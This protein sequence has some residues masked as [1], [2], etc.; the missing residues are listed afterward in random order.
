MPT[1]PTGDPALDLAN[2]LAPAAAL[3]A[4]DFAPAG[5]DSAA[6]VTLHA[7]TF[8]LPPGRGDYGSGA[9]EIMSTTD[10]FVAL[11]EFD[12]ASVGTALFAQSG[13][14]LPLDPESFSTQQLQRPQRGQGG[15][16]VFFSE[17]GRAFCAYVVIGSWAQ[18]AT[19]VPL[20][21]QLLAGLRVA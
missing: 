16:Q 1:P 7:A 20:A 8:P 2:G 19:L 14:T 21:S 15:L 17:A 13:L 11:L 6:L 12:A 5:V 10:V 3:S 9:V 4:A 18:R